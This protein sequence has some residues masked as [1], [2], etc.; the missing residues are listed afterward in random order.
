MPDYPLWNEKQWENEI[1]R[2][3]SSLAEFFRDLVYCLDLPVGDSPAGL[4]EAAGMPLDPVT[5]RSNEA[6]QQWKNDHENEDDSD[7][8][9]EYE[10]RRPV[11]FACVDALDQLA[12]EWNTL[13]MDFDD[14]QTFAAALGINGAFAKLLARTA[15]FT[16]PDRDAPAAL[17]I[18]LGRRAMED[19]EDLVSRLDD[20][21]NSSG[22]PREKCRYFRSR[23]AL[24]REQLADHLRELR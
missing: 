14:R 4:Q 6:L 16:E 10:P 2:H 13:T 20:F 21:A 12:V 11:S 7:D 24:V 5:S 1:R 23:L 9:V 8:A 17:L 15:D 22:I 19:L 18:T 3:E